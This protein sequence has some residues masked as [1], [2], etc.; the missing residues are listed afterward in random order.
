MKRADSSSEGST[1][2][3]GSPLA[4]KL[5]WAD[6]CDDSDDN[7]WEELKLPEPC[8]EETPL[9][10]GASQLAHIADDGA[11]ARP[12]QQADRSAA[13]G[14]KRSGRSGHGQPAQQS[15]FPKG[16]SAGT[17]AKGADGDARQPQVW[18]KGSGGN[19]R[20]PQQ[21]PAAAGLFPMMGFTMPP[22]GCSP[23]DAYSVLLEGM[24]ANLCNDV[25][26]DAMLHQAGLQGAV[27]QC[28]LNAK[29][30]ATI[31]LS[32]WHAAIMCYNH[33]AT[34]RWSSG[35]LTV[36]MK[37]PNGSELSPGSLA[38]QQQNGSAA[39][40]A[41]PG[42]GGGRWLRPGKAPM[43]AEGN[44]Y[45]GYEGSGGDY[46]GYVCT[47][48]AFAADGTMFMACAVDGSFMDARA[49]PWQPEV[50]CA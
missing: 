30:A 33:F 20:Q 8:R 21:S 47:P 31:V 2:G 46:G 18:R 45:L 23:M 13:K 9:V 3:F 15:G 12:K 29:G 49:A 27:L 17:P 1:V 42:R 37:L 25:C 4:S 26:L 32:H 28:D 22:Q 43:K 5:S 10:A 24:P 48:V 7:Q 19:R 14:Q 34:S 35:T 44:S 16:T 41:Q 11:W 50:P 36:T 40:E 38:E 6:L 39:N